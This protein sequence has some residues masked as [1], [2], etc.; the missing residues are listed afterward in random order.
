MALR[1]LHPDNQKYKANYM[2]TNNINNFKTLLELEKKYEQATE[3]RSRYTA[4]KTKDKMIMQEVAYE[5]NLVKTKVAAMQTQSDLPTIDITTET[6]F[7]GKGG[8]KGQKKI[9]GKQKEQKEDVAAI[10]TAGNNN[11]Q[12]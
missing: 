4:L 5:E 1:V 11:A 9:Q 7:K 12:Q 10:T 6:V 3:I 2:Q 8:K